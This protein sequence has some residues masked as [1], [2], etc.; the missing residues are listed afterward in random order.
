MHDRVS[1][2]RH[3]RAASLSILDRP[4]GRYSS[5]GRAGRARREEQLARTPCASVRAERLRRRRYVAVVA[6]AA[7]ATAAAVDSGCQ[8]A[9]A[10]S[11]P[12]AR[13]RRPGPMAAD[14]A[15]IAR[16]ARAAAAA[17][18]VEK[19]RAPLANRGARRPGIMARAPS[20]T[21]IVDASE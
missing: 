1:P 5:P 18:R 13:R 11:A 2:P 6:S 14:D 12:A 20:L 10:P 19:W 16:R 4:A 17:G 15:W 8:K 21:Q 3:S 7:G 9:L